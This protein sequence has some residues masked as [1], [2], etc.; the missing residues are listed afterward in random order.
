[1]YDEF[2]QMNN[3]NTNSLVTK[4]AKDMNRSLKKNNYKY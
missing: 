2:F 4:R 3:K 1:M